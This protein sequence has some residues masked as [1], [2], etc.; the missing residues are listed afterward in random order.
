[1]DF[2]ISKMT[3]VDGL[4]TEKKFDRTGEFIYRTYELDDKQ[5]LWKI[6]FEKDGWYLL[7]VIFK[8]D[9]AYNIE[10]NLNIYPE[11][12]IRFPKFTKTDYDSNLCTESTSRYQAET[13]LC[14]WWN[15]KW[16]PEYEDE[17][18]IDISVDDMIAL[19]DYIS[20]RIRIISNKANGKLPTS[21][22][23]KMISMLINIGNYINEEIISKYHATYQIEEDNTNNES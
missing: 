2:T 13:C 10:V 5:I 14:S 11:L 19:C 9:N 21:K 22:N 4:E 8:N 16:K 7:D 12:N 1:M 17:D 20:N 6:V 23:K 3:S 15:T 18:L